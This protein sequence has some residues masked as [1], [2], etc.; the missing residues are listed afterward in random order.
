MK[1]TAA[2][3]RVAA[4]PFQ[5]E[6]VDLAAPQDD[7]VLVRIVA[8]GVCHSDIAARDQ[9]LPIA[10][11][12]VLGHEGAG[13]VEKVGKSVTKL[14]PGDKVVLTIAF[15]GECT[16]CQRG[17]VAYCENG[18]SLNYSGR[19]PDGSPTLCCGQEPIGG[20]FFG[21]SSF[22]SYAICNQ[23]N[24]VKVHAGADLTMAAPL[25][26]G[27]QT[28]AG[29]VMRSLAALP[30]RAI[31]VFGGGS[32]G[33]SAA[34]GAAIRG[35]NPVIVIEPVA[36]RRA[37]ALEIGATHAIDPAAGDVTQ[38]IKA[39]CARGVDYVVDTTGVVP[40]IQAAIAAMAPHGTMVFLGVPKNPAAEMPLS[41]LGFLASG[42]T[43][44]A[45]I[46]GDTQPDT[47]IPELLALYEQGRLP[48]DK[49]VR[50]YP[51]AEI[52]AAVDD[53]LAGRV[54]KPVLVL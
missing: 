13:I 17:D 42:C 34:M 54:V 38:Q 51:F 15:C 26:C 43:L 49:L 53:Q 19:R 32:V 6:E 36:A 41:V 22:A 18:M 23:R 45:V 30:G 39:I 21:Q 10:I 3:T 25:G 40:V 24:A 16:N 5:L 27:V 1:I 12:A 20:H 28:G 9:T 35:C 2:L 47:F 48:V 44:K 11:P 52:N 7:E 50:A 14:A 37:L 31:A 46:E 33:L 4:Q 8:V 29:A